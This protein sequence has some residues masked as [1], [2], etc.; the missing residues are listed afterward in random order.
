[1]KK[2]FAFLLAGCML[3]S[4]F[5]CKAS[6]NLADQGDP[7]GIAPPYE[8]ENVDFTASYVR[9]DCYIDGA[10]F[11]QVVIARSLVELKDY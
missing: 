2:L 7:Q 5:G 9:T 10:K 11:P 6:V 3:L 8:P 1:M 4:F